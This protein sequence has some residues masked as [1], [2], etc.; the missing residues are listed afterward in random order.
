MPRRRLLKR[1]PRSPSAIRR[2]TAMSWP[3][4]RPRESTRLPR[5]VAMTRWAT[6]RRLVSNRPRP[7]VTARS[8]RPRSNRR[9]RLP[10]AAVAPAVL[11]ADNPCSRAAAHPAGLPVCKHRPPE[12]VAHR[13]APPAHKPHRRHRR[14][15]ARP[16]APLRLRPRE[17]NQHRQPPPAAVALAERRQASRRHQQV[18]SSRQVSRSKS[19][20]TEQ[21]VSVSILR[22]PSGKAGGAAFCVFATH[23]GWVVTR[24]RH[25]TPAAKETFD[26]IYFPAA[27]FYPLGRVLDLF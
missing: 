19:S 18:L 21:G 20:P 4:Q 27:Y 6:P 11:L 23:Q 10:A 26:Y 3:K 2:R 16:A 9:H 7:P 25:F 14:A 17:G 15:A 22:R 12:A 5:N 24:H 8:R 13:A 1:R